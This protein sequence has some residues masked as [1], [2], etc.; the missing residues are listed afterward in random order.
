M[1]GFPGSRLPALTLIAASLAA[2]ACGGGGGG[3]SSTGSGASPTTPPTTS[4]ATTPGVW[5]GSVASTATGQ[6]SSVVA[7]TG[8]DGYSVWMTTDGRVWGGQVPM[9]G[10][11]FNATFSGHMYDGVHFPDGTNPGTSSMM[12]DHHST[13][14]TSGHYSG[15]GDAGTFNMTLSP[16]WDR[17]ASL[18]TVAGVYT[19][20]TSSGYTMTMTLSANGQLTASDSRGCLLNGTVGVP[21]ATHN[22]YRI[23]AT[24]TSCGSLDGAYQGMGTLL[25]ADA[26]QDWMTAMQ[27][28]EH[29]GHSH[30]GPM[31]GGAPMM[32]HNTVPTGQRNLF[33]FSLVNANNAIMDA[34]AR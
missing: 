25:D 26:M 5:K 14:V 30:G 4:A 1:N 13:T 23:N 11:H 20:S 18:G 2:S 12:I 19:R 9:A 7:V 31:M 3:D 34:L 27:P 21:D 24:V 15:S 10:D 16:M 29:G 32:G 22:M 8:M 33:M 28:L 6:V 17:P